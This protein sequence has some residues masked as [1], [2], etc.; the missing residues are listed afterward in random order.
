V[1]RQR[2]N[3]VSHAILFLALLLSA[4]SA[5]TAAALAQPASDPSTPSDKFVPTTIVTVNV[6]EDGSANT[7]LTFDFDVHDLHG[8][9]AAYSSATH[10]PMSR[11]GFNPGS[12]D[13]ESASMM[14]ARCKIPLRRSG[15]ANSV[16]FDFRPLV[17]ALSGEGVPEL[18]AAISVPNK[19]FASCEPSP[20]LESPVRNTQVCNYQFNTSAVAAGVVHVSFGYSTAQMLRTSGILGLLLL[21]PVA[22]TLWLRRRALSAP[23]DARDAV[24]FSYFRF[25][26]FGTMGGIIIWWAAADLLQVS[27]IISF[28]IS[29]YVPSNFLGPEFFSWVVIWIAPACVYMVCLSLSAPIHRLRGTEYTPAQLF[30]ISFWTLATFAFPVVAIVLAIAIFFVSVRWGVVF[31]GVSVLALRGLQMKV[32]RSRGM[33]VHALATGEL[34][35]RALALASAAGVKL[36]QIYVL[37]TEHMRMANAFAHQA[38]NILLTDYLLKNMNRREV[39]AVIAHEISHL[40]KKHIPTRQIIFYVL[41]MAYIFG[42]DYFARSLPRWFP[43]SPLLFAALLFAVYFVS[44]MNEFAADAGAARLTGDPAS[45]MTSLVKLARLNTT[46]LEWGRIG[47]KALTHPSVSR[48]ISRLAH[49]ANI[50]ESAVP[51]ILAGAAAAPSDVYPLPPTVAPSAKVFSTLHKFGRNFRVA[52]TVAL[53]MA[54][55][56][57][58]AALAARSAH[59][60]AM[61]LWVADAFGLLLTLAVILFLSDRLPLTGLAKLES[62]LRR[63]AEKEGAPAGLPTGLFVGLSPDAEPRLYEHD[64]AWDLGFLTLS[65]DR[66]NYWGEEARFSVSREEIKEIRL[67]PGPCGWFESP[68]IYIS[69]ASS[70]GES[71]VFNIRPMK[72][73]SMLQMGRDTRS[74]AGEMENWYRGMAY[75]QKGPL[76]AA[77][78]NASSRSAQE[79]MAGG[80]LAAPS[81]RSVISVAPSSLVRLRGL[82]RNFLVTGLVSASVAIVAGLHFG[83]KSFL[84]EGLGNFRMTLEDSGWYVLGVALIVRAI[85]LWPYRRARRAAAPSRSSAEPAIVPEASHPV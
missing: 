20:A 47:E 45:M 81:F 76:F 75:S 28:W 17:Q 41:L 27:T 18:D 70:S 63:K 19:G 22:L 11:I 39:D 80:P 35:D 29:R 4:G 49:A 42:S 15:F 79:S 32:L 74:L 6:G 73:R 66:L 84:T 34:H 44:R 61:S 72:A 40:K 31:A 53:L 59:L 71:G 9:M 2:R 52:W 85:Q 33:E 23:P 48:R 14:Y 7:W 46:P 12:S 1:P 64:W 36:K 5:I 56:P 3:T 55:I 54:A 65:A 16:G 83:L 25:L 8:L 78:A 60:G 68:A 37:S 26:R 30:G 43:L 10:C 51:G 21:S 24:V 13:D 50:P 57:S 62:L 58:L 38:H 69:W 82:L 67:G 77:C